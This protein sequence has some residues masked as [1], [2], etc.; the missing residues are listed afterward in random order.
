MD[1]CGM[2]SF[3]NGRGRG[4]GGGGRAKQAAHPSQFGHGVGFAHFGGA[5]QMQPQFAGTQHDPSLYAPQR[6]STI[7]TQSSSAGAPP[8]SATLAAE[9]SSK[10]D[11][12]FTYVGQ[13]SRQ[14]KVSLLGMLSKHLQPMVLNGHSSAVRPKPRASLRFQA[15][16]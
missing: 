2:A 4:R 12:N 5:P 14:D 11:K 15:A 1:P 7:S 8:P 16:Y 13:M 9:R 10:M 6:A 3:N